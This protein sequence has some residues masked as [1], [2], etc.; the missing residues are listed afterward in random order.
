MSDAIRILLCED[1]TLMRQGLHTILELEPGFQVVGEA[2]DGEEAVSQYN[3][4]RALGNGPDIVLMDI[5]MP[6]MSGVQATAVLTTCDAA[7]RVIILTTFDYEE[8]VF[9][10]IKAGAMGYLLKDV[11]ADELVATMRQ[12]YA[13]EPSIQPKIASK[14]LLEF[15][16]KGRSPAETV[17]SFQQE[18]LSPREIE[19]LKLLAEGASNRKIAE[20]LVLAEGT[21]KNHVSTILSKLHTENR[22]QAVYLARKRNLL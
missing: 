18:E 12:V 19:I 9:D 10:A 14:L 11:P 13:G 8:Y 20:K 22:T 4:L 17:R 15:G 7:A 5:Q 16:R 21:V 3:T 1:Q 2:A 6:R